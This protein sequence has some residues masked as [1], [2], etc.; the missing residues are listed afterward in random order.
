MDSRQ[1][2]PESTAPRKQAD[3]EKAKA[4]KD[5]VESPGFDLY[6]KLAKSNL[7]AHGLSM[8]LIP[9]TWADIPRYLFYCVARDVFAETIKDARVEAGKYKGE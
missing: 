8:G 2:F 1:S 4:F 5:L 7:D 9:K 6:C 3:Q